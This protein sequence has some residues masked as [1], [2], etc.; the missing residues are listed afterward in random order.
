M[1]IRDKLQNLSSKTLLIILGI[2]IALTI[3]IFVWQS[4][5]Y[6]I[7]RDTVKSTVAKKSD[8][9]YS[10]K[11]DSLSFDAVS[12][13]ATLKNVSITPDTLR[14]KRMSIEDQPD[15]LFDIQIKSISVTGVKTD[16]AVI[17]KKLVGD[18]VILDHPLITIYNLKAVKKDS[19]IN[20]QTQEFYKQVLGNL[21]LIK[22]N[23]VL[24]NNVNIHGVDFYTK[25]KQFD[26]VNA[27]F[28]LEDLA[29]D[30]VTNLDTNR[31]LFSRQVAFTLDT[32]Y[33]YNNNRKQLTVKKIAFSGKYKTLL[34]DEINLNRFAAPAG[35]PIRL[36]DAK[37]L[38]LSGVN[39]NEIIKNKNLVVDTILCKQITYYQA[40]ANKSGKKGETESNDS[41]G[42][43]NA[44]GVAMKHLEFGDVKI[45]PFKKST[46]SVGK[47]SIKINGVK[48]ESIREL[49]DEPIKYSDEI[50]IATNKITLKSKD[51][52]YNYN[53]SNVLINSKSKELKIDHFSIVPYTGEKQFAAKEKFQQ[54]R[55]DVNLSG[56]TLKGIG[57]E[58]LLNNK[59]EASELVINNTT[60]KIYRD[61]QKPL[62]KESKVGNYP[63]QMIQKLD[64]P[65]NIRKA[66]LVN[67]NIEYREKE[68][69]SDSTGVVSFTGARLVITNI[70]NIPV[71]I[72]QNNE[73]NI[74]FNANALGS[75]PFKGN[76]KFLMN[77]SNGDF[78]VNGHLSA[79]DALKLN[80]V[81]I[82]MALVK[83]KSG[84]I[85]SLDFNFTGNNTGAKGTFVM[86]YEDFKVDVLKKDKKSGEVKKKGLITFVANTLV[87]N[88]NPQNGKLREETPSFERD[89]YKSFF[90][91]VWKTIFNGLK[92]TVGIPDI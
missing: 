28:Q 40:P 22:A 74:A 83:V 21:G 25:Q 86:K 81:S 80:K 53:F 15:F 58:N 76:F 82:P 45:V 13:F 70:T 64:M 92:S 90:N 12:G 67:A 7:V 5:K 33:N 57:M 73:L 9:L 42:F 62:K 77:S 54:D 31:I 41:T 63:S 48:S 55:Y 30:S 72:K 91:L 32:F 46:Y 56:I 10:V 6:K 61:L 24:V 3:V 84:K 69:A 71:A 43:I 66:T 68:I 78:V 44:Y 23:T 11:Y 26:A 18:S 49:S 89:V 27:N 34:F 2:L 50:A 38:K 19:K 37:L 8:S 47:I 85:N 35:D 59:I 14:L 36:V 65:V 60:A 88:N 79:F 4:N 1:S 39:T 87:K 51:N 16:K 17:G 29:I 75:I 52:K 20:S